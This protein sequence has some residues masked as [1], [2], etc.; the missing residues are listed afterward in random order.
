MS[1]ERSAEFSALELCKTKLTL[2]LFALI[3]FGYVQFDS[4]ESASR[5]RA[6]MDAEVIEGRPI[7]IRFARNNINRKSGITRPPSRTLYIGNLSFDMT[8]ESILELFKD[9]PNVIDVRVSVDGRTGILRGFAH[10]EF[11]DMESARIGFEALSSMAPKGRKLRVD[12]SVDNRT[13][14]KFVGGRETNN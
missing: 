2:G 10:A 5:A 12:Y 14:I 8:K 3:R 6:E 11:L 1:G 7:V 13:V 9:I 4:T